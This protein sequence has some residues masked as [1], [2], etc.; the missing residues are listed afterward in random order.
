MALEQAA[1]VPRI[2]HAGK[3]NATPRSTKKQI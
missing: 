1:A 3:A 2:T